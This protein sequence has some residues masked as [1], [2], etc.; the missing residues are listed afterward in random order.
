MNVLDECD[1]THTKINSIEFLGNFSLKAKPQLN[2]NFRLQL[3]TFVVSVCHST[4]QIS[5]WMNSF[6]ARSFSFVSW[7]LWWHNNDALCLL[8]E[9]THAVYGRARALSRN[10]PK[11]ERKTWIFYFKCPPFRPYRNMLKAF[12][13]FSKRDRRGSTVNDVINARGVY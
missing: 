12:L 9:V 10:L 8:A 3:S 4:L 2:S 5:L 13:V 11:M 6:L 1:R 7:R